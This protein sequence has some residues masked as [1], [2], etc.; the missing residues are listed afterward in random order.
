MNNRIQRTRLHEGLLREGFQ[1]WDG[2]HA[3]GRPANN[4]LMLDYDSL[5]DSNLALFRRVIAGLCKLTEAY[6]PEFVTG[7]PNGATGYATRV[8]AELGIQTVTLKKRT[9]NNEK[10]LS[11]ASDLDEYTAAELARGVILEDVIN[12]RSSAKVVQEFDGLAPK[13]VAVVAIFDR[14]IPSERMDLGIP[15]SSMASEP[16]P[17]NLKRSELWQF[18]K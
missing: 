11:Y 6:N 4:K 18:A 5:H 2:R 12:S 7:V 15:V 17:A 16:I 9:F 1:R 13:M 8:A 14:G 10:Q 3:G